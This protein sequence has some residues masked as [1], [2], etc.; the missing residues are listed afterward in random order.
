LVKA[1][2]ESRDFNELRLLPGLRAEGEWQNDPVRA[3]R[4]ILSF[5]PGL[6]NMNISSLKAIG[7]V[8]PFWSLSALIEDVRKAEPDYQR[9]AGDYDSWYLRDEASGEYVKGFENW[10]KVDGA[11]IRFLICGPLHWLGILDL[12]AP[13]ENQPPA[14]FRFTQAAGYLLQGQPPE[15]LAAKETELILPRSDARVWVPRL[16]PRSVRYQLARFC[17]WEEEKKEGYF[18]RITPQSLERARQSGLRI[19]Q[20][21]Q[22]LRKHAEAVPPTLL[23]ALTRWEEYGSE[24]RFQK[25]VILRLGNPQ[26]LQALQNSR[27]SRYLGDPLSSTTIL[28][29]PDAWPQVMAVLAELGYLSEV[30]WEEGE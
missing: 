15:G 9:L 21:I 13:A 14:A 10:E 24:A 1:W 25:A 20:F 26:T 12:A 28:V 3:R 18:Y 29:N 2:L 27:A 30:R 4:A 19:N 23:K 7:P 16:A 6:E 22:F 17:A 8:N 5:L 11:L